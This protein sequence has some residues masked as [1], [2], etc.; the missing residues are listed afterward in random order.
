VSSEV[1]NKTLAR[2]FLEASARGDLD[3]MDEMMAPT[4]STAA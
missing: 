4:S 1:K 3:A 2:R